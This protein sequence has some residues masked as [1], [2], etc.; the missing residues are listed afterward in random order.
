MSLQGRERKGQ[1]PEIGK[2]P[3][4]K[5]AFDPQMVEVVCGRRPLSVVAPSTR[6][7][8]C[9]LAS[10]RPVRRVDGVEGAQSPPLARRRRRG[11]HSRVA[12]RRSA[13]SSC[14]DSWEARPARSAS[15]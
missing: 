6:H 2:P 8:L 4:A 12:R 1:V 13:S 11:H 3:C 5:R 7:D 10:R 14:P 9:H 15:R